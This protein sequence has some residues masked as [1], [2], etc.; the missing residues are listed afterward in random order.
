MHRETHKMSRA[1]LSRPDAHRAFTCLRDRLKFGQSKRHKLRISRHNLCM[2]ASAKLA[3]PVVADQPILRVA[4]QSNK[5][6]S[7]RLSS[8]ALA[9]IVRRRINAIR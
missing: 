4:L 6:Y 1:A 2:K 9:C 5:V 7:V 3:N 8:R